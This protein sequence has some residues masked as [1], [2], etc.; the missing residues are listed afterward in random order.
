MAEV[1]PGAQVIRG[2]GIAAV[3]GAIVWVGFEF[4]EHRIRSH[5]QACV[6]F[7]TL[8]KSNFK[9]ARTN[10][11]VFCSIAQKN[12]ALFNTQ[13]PDFSVPQYGALVPPCP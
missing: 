5:T 8:I 2:L 11:E 9:S 10:P 13:C 12:I 7:A 4:A 6:S 1:P 3:E